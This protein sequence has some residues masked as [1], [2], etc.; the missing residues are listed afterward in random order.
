[1]TADD[2]LVVEPI[3]GALHADVTLPGSKSITNRALITAALAAGTT[4]LTGVGL[5]DDTHAM[6]GA[7][8]CVGVETEIAADGT[9]VT[10]HGVG[11]NLVAPQQELDANMSG[12]S[13][14]FLL[15]VLALIGSGTLTGHEQMRAR[16]MATLCQALTDLGAQ[17]DN[18]S[19]PITV[20]AP[21]T[22]SAV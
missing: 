9:T 15:P 10:V 16:P 22:G 17:V 19:L 3:V 2:V 18:E 4:T 6:I 1:M 11:P 20:S 13:A 7:L 5:S 21:V 8:A 12:T 14:R